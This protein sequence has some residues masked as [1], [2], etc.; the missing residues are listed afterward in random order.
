MREKG[1][2]REGRGG[3]VRQ[4]GEEARVGGEG[5]GWVKAL[6]AHHGREAFVPSTPLPPFVLT[7]TATATAVIR[8]LSILL[9][10]FFVVR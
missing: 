4:V 9:S 5:M 1:S 6:S 7:L 10:P 3:V 2:S 8:P